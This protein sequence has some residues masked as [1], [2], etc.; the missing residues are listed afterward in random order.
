MKV[1]TSAIIVL[2]IDSTFR[3]E[4]VIAGA[5]AKHLRQDVEATKQSMDGREAC[6]CSRFSPAMTK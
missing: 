2:R 1:N 3:T 6:E 5:Y 4:L